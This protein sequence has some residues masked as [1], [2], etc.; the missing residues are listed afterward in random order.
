MTACAS[1]LLVLASAGHADLVVLK[2]GNTMEGIISKQDKKMVRLQIDFESYIELARDQIA[3]VKKQTPKQNQKIRNAWETADT[4]LK[5]YEDEPAG[6]AKFLE[7]QRKK[8]LR[9]YDGEWMTEEEIRKRVEEDNEANRTG[10]PAD[11]GVNP[12]EMP[13]VK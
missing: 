7:A 13:G 10:P 6:S 3:A 8:G 12:N 1:L 11:R 4:G 5:K 2:N 9:M